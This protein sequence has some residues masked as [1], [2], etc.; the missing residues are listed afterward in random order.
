MGALL[1]H[2]FLKRSAHGKFVH[3]R[4]QNDSGVL[5]KCSWGLF[6]ENNCP[7]EHSVHFSAL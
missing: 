3:S 4:G 6:S 7:Y 5:I 1:C 2:F